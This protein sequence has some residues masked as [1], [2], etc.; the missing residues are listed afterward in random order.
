MSVPTVSPAGIVTPE[1]VLLEFSEAGLGSRALAFVVDLGVRIGMVWGVLLALGV[2]GVVIDETTV[3]VVLTASVFAA[4][5]VYPV[6][7]ETFAHGRT[8][9]K[10]VV[11]LRVVTVEGAPA[12]FRH[13]AI[14]SA[15]GLVDF[16]LGAGSIAIVSTLVT[17]HHQRLGDVAAGTIVIRERQAGGLSSPV[18]FSPPPGWEPYAA[19]VDVSGLGHDG[20]V[21]VRSF[22]LRAPGFSP[23]ARAARAG[24]L[25]D[26]VARAIGVALPAGTDAEAFLRAVAAAHQRRF[27]TTPAEPPAAVIAGAPPPSVPPPVW[28]EDQPPPAWGARPDGGVGGER[29]LP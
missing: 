6:V 25:A 18:A 16:L 22:L 1:A 19:A 4:L 14:R 17:R 10:M 28:V 7:F 21:L 2:G 9:G 24:E 26:G 3:V 20:Y 12:R 5:L 13:A 11:G 23:A 27:G 15:L 8:P 29:P